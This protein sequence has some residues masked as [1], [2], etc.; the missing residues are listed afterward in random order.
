MDTRPDLGDAALGLASIALDAARIPLRVAQRLPGMNHLARE[1]AF[2]RLRTRS[3]LEGLLDDVLCAPEVERAVDRILAGPLPDAVV[4]SLL[5]HQVVE[6]L[7]AELAAD[8]D[9]DLAVGA[10]LEHETTQRLV[11]AIVASPGLDQ[12]LVQAT[13]RV[14]R[15]PELQRVVEHVAH[16]PEVR[17]A[18]T[19]QST[20]MA[21]ELADGLRTRAETLDDVA[22]RTVRGWLRRP[23]PA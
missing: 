1:G 4:R 18:L 23:H 13:D 15:G 9:V 14:L 16:S 22:E 5:E 6:R 17:E 3:R 20:T 10:A 12:L 11:A 19:Q 8:V 2:V 21:E 7:A